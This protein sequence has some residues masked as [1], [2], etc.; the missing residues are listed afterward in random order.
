ML[1]NGAGLRNDWNGRRP[2]DENR[3]PLHFVRG[4]VLANET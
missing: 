1:V 4:G 3:R 2:M